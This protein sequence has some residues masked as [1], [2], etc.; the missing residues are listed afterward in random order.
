MTIKTEQ[1]DSGIEF[2]LL[3]SWENW[4]EHGVTDLYFYNVKLRPE[5]FG[6]DFIKQYEGKNIDM[7]LWL[8]SSTIEIYVDGFEDAV[9]TKKLKL[10]IV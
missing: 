5:V 2:S 3:E 1:E 4:D 7:G 6:E 10:V 8:A 9:L